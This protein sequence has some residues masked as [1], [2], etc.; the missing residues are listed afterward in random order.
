MPIITLT[1]DMGIKDHYVAS[2]KGNILSQNPNL[3]I[4]DVSHFIKPFDIADAAFVLRSCIE[5]FPKGTIHI[6]GVDTEPII[7]FGNNDGAFPSLLLFK[8]QYIIAN[9]NGFF[10]AF[11]GEDRP[12][13]L[14]R[15]DDILSNPNASSTFP[16]KHLLIPIALK[17]AENTPIDSF[18]SPVQSYKRAFLQTALYELNL[19]KGNIIQIDTYGNLITN[20]TKDMF[21]GIGKGN[22]FILYYR[23]KEYHIDEISNS[24]NSVAPGERVAVF[25]SNNLLEIA[26]NRGANSGLG[27]ANKMFGMKIGDVV[28]VE[29][30]PQGSR[31]TLESLF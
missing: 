16:T 4:V 2:L 21:K 9:D 11:L 7:N 10:G 6:V 30:T 13:G 25:N 14:Y 17:L 19:I 28:R 31:E 12:Q 18:A 20:I 3:Q 15:I 26:I 1:T 27:G 24:Y 8:D 29:F 23:N 5:D 22:P